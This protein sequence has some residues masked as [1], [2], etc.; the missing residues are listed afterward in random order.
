MSER[1]MAFLKKELP[2]TLECTDLNE[3]LI[4]LYM[5][6]EIKGFNKEDRYNDFGMRAQEVYD[7][8]YENND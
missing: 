2:E 5:L 6:I 8:L 3:A 1:S 4:K 7:D